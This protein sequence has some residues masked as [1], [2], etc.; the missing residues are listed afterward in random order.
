MKINKIYRCGY[1]GD[2]TNNL[3]APLTGNFREK[4]IELIES[5]KNIEVEQTHG[6]CC[7]HEWCDEPQ[8]VQVT[9]DMAIDAGDRSMEGRWIEW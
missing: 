9:R 4:V 6:D 8:M 1:C 3:G 2:V 5:N 7:S